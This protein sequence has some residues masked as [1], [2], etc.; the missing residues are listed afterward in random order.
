[1]GAGPGRAG[2]GRHGRAAPR[3]LA[4]STVGPSNQYILPRRPAN[5]P[6][7]PETPPSP[8]LEKLPVVLVLNNF[9]AFYVA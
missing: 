7:L 9:P 8:V 2:P 3:S 4:D 5:R 6:R 1:M